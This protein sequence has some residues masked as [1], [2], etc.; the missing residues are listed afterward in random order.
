MTTCRVVT[1]NK[2]GWGARVLV[3]EDQ[4]PLSGVTSISIDIQPDDLVRATI[5]LSAYV[6]VSGAA[7]LLGED[8]LR[9]CADVLGFD[10]VPRNG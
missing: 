8:T 7:L 6:D 9:R 5:E 3:G 4:T 10:L 1:E 2:V